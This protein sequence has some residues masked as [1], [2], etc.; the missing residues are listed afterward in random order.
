MTAKKPV[1]KKEQA[2][3]HDLV[4][5]LRAVLRERFGVCA[6]ERIGVAVSGGADSVALLRLFVEL[7]EQLG[8]VVCVAHFNH[9]LRGKASDADEKF[10]AK[11]SAQDGLEFFVERE[12]VAAKAKR[13]R[14]NLEDAARRARY[15]F[16]ERLAKEGRVSRVAVAQTAD[17]QAE[18]VLAHIMRGTGL[19]GLAGIHPQ[20]GSV[21]RPLLGIRRA[22]LRSYLRDKRQTWRE[23]AT[24]RNETRTRA[25]IRYKL[26]PFLEKKFQSSVVEH[27]CQLAELAREDN[28]RLEFESELRLSA[29]AKEGANGT[30][31][32]IRELGVGRRPPKSGT[33]NEEAFWREGARAMAKRMVR[34]LVKRVKPGPG[35]LTSQHV[36]S[37]LKLAEEG[38]SGKILPLPGGVEVRR[39]R[40]SLIFRATAFDK[41]KAEPSTFSLHVDWPASGAELRLDAL[42]RILRFRVIDWPSEGRETTKIG[43][44][45]DRD[46]LCAPLELRNWRPGDAMRP[47]GHQN[48]HTLARL[49]NELGASRWEKERWPVL[50]SAGKVAWVLGLPVADEFAV[51]E[52]SRAAVV[53]TEESSS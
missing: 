37:V 41:G 12:N 15:A 35:E 7:R 10:V 22:A 11:F 36:E 42:S 14:A 5:S 17:D 33:R 29:A 27:L 34:Q 18:T 46:R 21:F 48:R 49:L 47:V 26:M 39:E 25:R 28:A 31:V 51:A 2:K 6:G 16:F 19:A 30:A 8:V 4:E 13:E 9:K 52:G 50:T 40:D 32:G 44:V 43:A 1:K 53:I 3:R 20:A 23:D 38:H 24:N 45:L